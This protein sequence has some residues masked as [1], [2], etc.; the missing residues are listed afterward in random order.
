[1]Y[2]SIIQAQFP[3]DK[4]EAAA[5][6][7]QETIANNPPVGWQEGYLVAD[8]GSGQVHAVAL[9]DTETNAKAYESSGRFQ[10]DVQQFARHLTSPPSRST[11]DILAQGRR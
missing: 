2:A 1:M 6:I 3:S 9:W 7:W 11:G 5:Q 4:V 8:R 10:Q